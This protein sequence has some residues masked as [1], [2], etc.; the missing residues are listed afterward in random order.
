MLIVDTHGQR[1]RE[2][3]GAALPLRGRCG[4]LAR[5]GW[6]SL[7]ALPHGVVCGRGTARAGDQ[8]D[9]GHRRPC[10][11][12]RSPSGR[13]DRA[14]LHRRPA[15]DGLSARDVEVAR[16]ISSEAPRQVGRREA[17]CHTQPS[18]PGSARR[19]AHPTPEPLGS[20][21]GGL[22]MGTTSHA[23][24]VWWGFLRRRRYHCRCSSQAHPAG[25]RE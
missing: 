3:H 14:P 12:R 10:F 7:C 13:H 9:C 18:T 21:G 1:P 23:G 25:R 22:A 6:R 11:R 5:G 24:R 15:P 20:S 19:T 4:V 16:L 2:D 17:S 8:R